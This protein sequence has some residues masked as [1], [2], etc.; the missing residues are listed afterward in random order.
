MILSTEGIPADMQSRGVRES[1]IKRLQHSYIPSETAA[2][3]A[4][5]GELAPE[6]VMLAR[7][8]ARLLNRF[9]DA[10]GDLSRFENPPGK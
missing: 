6:S 10:D 1:D 2:Q 4:I 3:M 7:V 5:E 8:A 9:Y